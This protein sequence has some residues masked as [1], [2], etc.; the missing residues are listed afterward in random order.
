MKSRTACVCLQKQWVDRKETERLVANMGKCSQRT[1][2]CEVK[3]EGLMA[4]TDKLVAEM[5]H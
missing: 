5:E 1:M 4:K 2:D 3:M